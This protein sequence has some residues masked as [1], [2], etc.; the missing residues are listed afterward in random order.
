MKE[1]L[2]SKEKFLSLYYFLFALGGILR[3]EKEKYDVCYL[4][5][6]DFNDGPDLCLNLNFCL[7]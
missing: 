2:F 5:S 3:I 7:L 1:K 6:W 4:H